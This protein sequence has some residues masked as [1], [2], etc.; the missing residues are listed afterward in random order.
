M[1][2]RIQLLTSLF[3]LVLLTCSTTFSAEVVIVTSF[4]KDLFD[5]YQAA[6]EE[7]H[8]DIKLVFRSKKTAAAVTY[9]R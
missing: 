9:I 1:N 3:F 2:N 7:K 8:Q 6:F 4:P 5:T